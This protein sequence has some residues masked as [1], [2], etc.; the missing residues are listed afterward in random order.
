MS[1]KRILSVLF[2]EQNGLCA[3]CTK[4]MKLKGHGHDRATVDHMIPKSKGGASAIYNY[5][6]ACFCCNNTKADKLLYVFLEDLS[7]RLGL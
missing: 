1:R 5:A 7:R 4:P 3:Y 2:R 6:A